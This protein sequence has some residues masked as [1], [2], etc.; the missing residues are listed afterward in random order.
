M[1]SGEWSAVS[2]SSKRRLLAVA[3]MWS[4][5]R[6]QRRVPITSSRSSPW[7]RSSKRTRAESRKDSVGLSDCR[8]RSSTQPAAART[9]S[10]GVRRGVRRRLRPLPS[11]GTG[12]RCRVGYS[13]KRRSRRCAGV[14]RSGSRRPCSGLAAGALELFD[15]EDRAAAGGH[16]QPA[17]AQAEEGPWRS[18]RAFLLQNLHPHQLDRLAAQLR[19]DTGPGRVGAQ[20][21]A[22]L[23]RGAAPVHAAALAG[24]PR[25]VGRPRAVL[26]S[27]LDRSRLQPVEGLDDQ[28]AAHRGE[29]REQLPRRLLGTDLGLDLEQDGPGVEPLLH[30]HRGHA[31]AG[32][33]GGDRGLDRR[34][35]APAREQRGVQV[36]A[37]EPRQPEEVAR[38]DLAE[39]D[40][41][42]DVGLKLRH[43]RQEVGVADPLRLQDLEPVLAGPA[44]HRRVLE[45]LAAADRARRLG[46]D[47]QG[48]APRLDQRGERRDGEVGGAEEEDPVDGGGHGR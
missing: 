28:P 44:R 37:A 34:R 15:A 10:C 7:S 31:G 47:A 16:G 11:W 41:H 14:R 5:R 42:R 20:P 18:R 6:S 35:A 30:Q 9:L 32:L 3:M 38:E 46:D 23:A 1:R 48:A 24:E 39:G 43:L 27:R 4:R 26:G 22:D 17:A 12:E 33:P 40:D 36:D 13:P 45:L 25:R 29:A 19:G 2:I 21:V 8:V